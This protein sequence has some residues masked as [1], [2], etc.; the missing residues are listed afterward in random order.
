MKIWLKAD[1][2]EVLT[3]IYFFGKKVLITIVIKYN[4]AILSS[5]TVECVFS[6]GRY[7]FRAKKALGCQ[8]WEA[9]GHEGEPLTSIILRQ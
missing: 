1:S 2:K 3:G 5:A 6:I 8:F 4:T 7:I 9:N